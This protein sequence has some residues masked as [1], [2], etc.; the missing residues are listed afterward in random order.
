LSGQLTGQLRSATSA[1]AC[2]RPADVLYNPRALT[3]DRDDR[4]TTHS[5]APPIE[6][7]AELLRLLA[8]ATPS[9]GAA[10]SLPAAPA[11]LPGAAYG[12]AMQLVAQ[13]MLA[14][15]ASGLRSWARTAE[16][17]GKALPL[18][19]DSLAAAS[20]RPNGGPADQART[21]DEL[22]ACLR[23]LAELPGR[24]SQRLQLEI[25]RIVLGPG[26]GAAPEAGPHWRRWES[27]P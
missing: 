7:L 18:V 23:E 13:V 27:K 2:S 11:V 1:A 19:M 8:A 4:S 24:E 5:G 15:A 21:L 22:R 26:T 6:A 25:E 10:P 16:I 12:P 9:T 3:A 14:W 20:G 17:C